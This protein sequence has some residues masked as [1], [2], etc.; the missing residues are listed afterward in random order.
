MFA[1]LY[2][3][4]TMNTTARKI[5]VWDLPVRLFHL[6]LATGFLGS[7][8]IAKG[9]G[10]DSQSFPY[11][12]MIGMTLALMVLLRLIWGIVGTRWAKFS[13]LHLWPSEIYDYFRGVLSSQGK[14]YVGHNPATSVMMLV[15]FVLVLALGWTG[16][17]KATGAGSE[18]I[19]G[20]LAN[21]TLALVAF[22]VVGVIIHSVRKRDGIIP[23]MVHGHK[24]GDPA[25]AIQGPR[26]LA[27]VAFFAVIGFFFGSLATSF[28]ATTQSTKWP[29]V[30]TRL[31][32]GES[33]QESSSRGMTETEREAH[34]TER[35]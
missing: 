23:G 18:S 33:E 34:E 29:I 24:R 14:G 32:L 25:D 1:R 6:L 30:G 19:H 3:E 5:M 17:Q 28:D 35:E 16:Y 7:Y 8:L 11:H 4:N 26:A 27:G 13:G 15:M 22:H 31:P 21:V 12:S 20:T 2:R 9:M 10:E